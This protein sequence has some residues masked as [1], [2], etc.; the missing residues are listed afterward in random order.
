[1]E[2]GVSLPP[3]I[4][5]C[6]DFIENNKRKRTAIEVS[7]YAL[8]RIL[9]ALLITRFGEKAYT[10]IGGI[11]SGSCSV[12][13]VSNELGGAPISISNEYVRTK[14]IKVTMNNYG[15]ERLAA[16]VCLSQFVKLVKVTFNLGIILGW[17]R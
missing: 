3:Q 14:T 10:M 6:S 5:Q 16:W 8:N 11:G 12:M 17:C 4:P 1:M 7:K 15:A 2:C 13:M 9:I